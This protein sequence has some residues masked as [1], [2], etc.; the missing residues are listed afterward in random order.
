MINSFY[1]KFKKKIE[2][3]LSDKILFNKDSFETKIVSD[4]FTSKVA[5]KEKLNF[6]RKGQTPHSVFQQNFY[7]PNS[8]Y[9]RF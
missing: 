2:I 1:E 4:I 6:L 9:S 5:L 3:I 8:N 7:F